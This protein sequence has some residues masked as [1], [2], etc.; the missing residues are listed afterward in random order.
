MQRNYIERAKNRLGKKEY[1]KLVKKAEKQ[2]RLES[3]IALTPA[4]EE[5]FEDS[6]DDE[7]EDEF[8][9]LDNKD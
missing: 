8:G 4:E 2:E 3:G 6:S 1:E 9:V 5:Y 7:P